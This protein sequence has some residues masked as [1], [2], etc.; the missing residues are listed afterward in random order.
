M[1]LKVGTVSNIVVSFEQLQAKP[2]KTRHQRLN[3]YQEPADYD[4]SCYH[5]LQGHDI[6]Q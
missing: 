5:A 3:S 6:W 4:H 2:D 1:Q